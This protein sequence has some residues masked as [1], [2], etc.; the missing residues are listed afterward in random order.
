MYIKEMWWKETVIHSELTQERSS[1]APGYVR[2]VL[3]DLLHMRQWDMSRRLRPASDPVA[4]C[5]YLAV[6]HAVYRVG[7]DDRVLG[8]GQHMTSPHQHRLWPTREPHRVVH[9]QVRRLG[10][11]QMRSGEG[12]S[13]CP[14][15]TV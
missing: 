2:K 13:E 11:D 4:E 10:A 9:V 6:V 15:D 3:I 14:M 8:V 5:R 12:H 1:S 7:D